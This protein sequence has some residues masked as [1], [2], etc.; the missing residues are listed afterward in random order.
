[1]KIVNGHSISLFKMNQKNAFYTDNL[2]DPESNVLI[3]ILDS[4]IEQVDALTLPSDVHRKDIVQAIQKIESYP[5]RLSSI[6]DYLIDYTYHLNL[7][8]SQK[9]EQLKETLEEL[10]HLKKFQESNFTEIKSPNKIQNFYNNRSI[11]DSCFEESLNS[12]KKIQKDQSKI[13]ND[14]YILSLKKI[15][16][17]EGRLYQ[18]LNLIV[19]ENQQLHRIN[20][21]LTS[22]IEKISNVKCFNENNLSDTDD[23]F[24]IDHK[25]DIS[26]LKDQFNQIESDLVR[27]KE[28]VQHKFCL[29]H[30]KK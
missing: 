17:K 7:E 19:E 2:Q 18:S 25:V 20:N 27:L 28:Q 29:M 4:R 15:N 21:E 9:D 8:L 1:M 3:S 5:K 12:L 11:N 10:A 30:S 24:N 6:L 13:N 14:D 26:E 16:A 23:D 22:K